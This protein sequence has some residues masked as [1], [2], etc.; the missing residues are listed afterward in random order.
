M[1]EHLQQQ[2]S[3]E[4][5]PAANALDLFGQAASDHLPPEAQLHMDFLTPAQESWL[6]DRIDALAWDTRIARRRR[7]EDGGMFVK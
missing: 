2:N 7:A 6:M 4:N 5:T 1:S 3:G